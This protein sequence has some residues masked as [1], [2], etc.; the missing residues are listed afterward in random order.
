MYIS[1]L[2]NQAYLEN[3]C[4]WSRWD[5]FQ[6]W[7]TFLNSQY[8]PPLPTSHLPVPNGDVSVSIP[9]NR[10]SIICPINLAT[11]R[12]KLACPTFFHLTYVFYPSMPKWL[13]FGPWRAYYL[14][15]VDRSIVTWSDGCP[16]KM[17]IKAFSILLDLFWLYHKKN[18]N[19]WFRNPKRYKWEAVHTYL[20][21]E[22][23]EVIEARAFKPFCIKYVHGHVF[24]S[25]V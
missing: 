2:S 21:N 18:R 9:N 23:L 16:I 17:V 8:S 14:Y 5:S 22:G 20:S 19:V 12:R 15:F 13:L 11:I 7:H 4:D 6:Q 24:I 25:G 10:K 3:T 1:T